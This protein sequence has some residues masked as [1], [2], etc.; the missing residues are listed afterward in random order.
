MTTIQS[1]RFDE[2]DDEVLEL[3]QKGRSEIVTIDDVVVVRSILEP[4][5][6]WLEHIKP[7]GRGLGKLPPPPS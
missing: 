4:G 7:D 6:S 1:K 2:P 3:G 5:C